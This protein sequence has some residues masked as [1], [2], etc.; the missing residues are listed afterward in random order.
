MQALESA[1][2]IDYGAEQG[3]GPEPGLMNDKATC[4]ELQYENLE[5]LIVLG[6]A[7]AAEPQERSLGLRCYARDSFLG[8]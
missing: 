2:E 5:Q 4:S 8:E 3:M 6:S 1:A 7:T